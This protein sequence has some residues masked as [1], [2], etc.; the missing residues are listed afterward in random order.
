MAAAITGASATAFD[1]TFGVMV[2]AAAVGALMGFLLRR[3]VTAEEAGEEG[4]AASA[5]ESMARG[6]AYPG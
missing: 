3:T 5:E 1:D 4:R 6:G 2:A